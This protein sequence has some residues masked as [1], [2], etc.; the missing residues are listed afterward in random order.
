MELGSGLAL[1]AAGEVC[2]CLLLAVLEELEIVWREVGDVGAA[3]VADGD[4]EVHQ[5]DAAAED[6]LLG[7]YGDGRKRDDSHRSETLHLIDPT[8]AGPFGPG[9]RRCDS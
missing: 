7:R 3:L 2:D 6:R 8:T 5:V 1:V 9:I 4:A